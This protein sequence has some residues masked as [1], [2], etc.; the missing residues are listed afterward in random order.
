MHPLIPDLDLSIGCNRATTQDSNSAV[1][2][3]SSMHSRSSSSTSHNIEFAHDCKAQDSNFNIPKLRMPSIGV[4]GS[5]A[6]RASIE[7]AY[8]CAAKARRKTV[9]F[10]CMHN[11]NVKIPRPDTKYVNSLMDKDIPHTP[12]TRNPITH[13]QKRRSPRLSGR[14]ISKSPQFTLRRLLSARLGSR[15]IQTTREGSLSKSRPIHQWLPVH[16]A[17]WLTKLGDKGSAK[18]AIF[19]H[20][21]GRDLIDVRDEEDLIRLGWKSGNKSLTRIMH[22]LRI[23]QAE[24]LAWRV[25]HLTLRTSHTKD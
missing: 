9:P 3:S 13:R 7:A 12:I 2:E 18:L 5:Q 8:H 23:L 16:V 11:M 21:R 20:I 14:S 22:Q 6:Y 25:N 24:D 17:R 1:S 19:N 10:S 15:R 4:E